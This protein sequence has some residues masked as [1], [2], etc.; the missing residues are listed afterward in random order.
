VEEGGVKTNK[1]IKKKKK[2][3]VVGIIS[4]IVSNLWI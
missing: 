2:V 1:R 3:F 4:E